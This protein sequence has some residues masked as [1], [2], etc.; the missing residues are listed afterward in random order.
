M[1][2]FNYKKFVSL[3]NKYYAERQHYEEAI[4]KYNKAKETYRFFSKAEN[5]LKKSMEQLRKTP[6]FED[7][8]TARPQV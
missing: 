3:L 1:T 5:Q 6:G 8:I 2:E 4:R 7:R